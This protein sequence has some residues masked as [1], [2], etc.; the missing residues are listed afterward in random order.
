M[1]YMSV[2]WVEVDAEEYDQELDDRVEF[3]ARLYEIIDEDDLVVG[4]S[5]GEPAIW[6]I[7]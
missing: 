1:N 2:T 3:M 4:T 6:G 5:K 7:E